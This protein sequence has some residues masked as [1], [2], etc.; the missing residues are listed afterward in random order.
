MDFFVNY[1]HGWKELRFITRTSEV[2][3][4]KARP[5]PFGPPLFQRKPQPQA[6]N[7]AI[8][9]RDGG[10]SRASVVIHR[11]MRLESGSVLKPSTRQRFN[12]N[13]TSPSELQ[14]FGRNADLELLSDSEKRKELLIIVK[15]GCSADISNVGM[16]HDDGFDPREWSYGLSWAHI[17][18]TC[19]SSR[20]RLSQSVEADIYDDPDEYRFPSYLY[21]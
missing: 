2:F 16:V 8:L 10:D 15:R 6:W 4:F 17:R 18:M 21:S 3:A 7:E 1:G 14:R 13:V 9:R 5:D 12:Q 20:D 19:M 11:S